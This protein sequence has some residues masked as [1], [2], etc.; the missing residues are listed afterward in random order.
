MIGAGGFLFWWTK[1]YDFGTEEIP[2]CIVGSLTG[3]LSW[4][5]GWIIHGNS[6]DTD[7]CK[8]LIRRRHAKKE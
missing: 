4:F 8:I 2:L 5:L 6:L 3:P 7:T 1:D